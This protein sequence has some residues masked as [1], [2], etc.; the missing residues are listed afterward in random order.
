[1]TWGKGGGAQ[2]ARIGCFRISTGEGVNP[3]EI[4]S[5]FHDASVVR[6]MDS[7][8][9]RQ[10]QLLHS[11][12]EKVNEHMLDVQERFQDA[13][14]GFSEGRIDQEFMKDLVGEAAHYQRERTFYREQLEQL[15]KVN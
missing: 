14:N 6:K 10:I 7:Y 15:Q 9:R 5:V 3:G 1:M 4:W 8:D 2:F 12:I 11:Y 13:L